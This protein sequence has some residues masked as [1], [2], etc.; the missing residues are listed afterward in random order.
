MKFQHCN[1]EIFYRTCQLSLVSA[2][3]S[4]VVVINQRSEQPLRYNQCLV[5]SLPPLTYFRAQQGNEK[6]QHPINYLLFGK[7]LINYNKHYDN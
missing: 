4:M 2:Q 5:K 1:K 3:C 6:S 7:V